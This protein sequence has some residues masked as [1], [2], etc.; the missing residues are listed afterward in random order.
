MQRDNIIANMDATDSY[1]SSSY[2]DNEPIILRSSTTT[3]IRQPIITNNRL[4][5]TLPIDIMNASVING[6]KSLTPPPPT[7]SSL[8]NNIKSSSPPAS[9]IINTTAATTTNA[10][11]TNSS[12]SRNLMD[13]MKER[14][15]QEVRR[16]LNGSPFLENQTA[17]AVRKNLS[18]PSMPLIYASNAATTT[19]N[20]SNITSHLSNNNII[21]SPAATRIPQRPLVQSH[22]FTTY[23]KSPP[24]PLVKRQPVH[25]VR[26]ASTVNELYGGGGGGGIYSLNNGSKPIQV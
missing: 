13:R 17:I 10:T 12:S 24:T 15:R 6:R 14:H 1:F 5:N 7:S 21:T 8:N 4:S 2:A 26:S 3:P 25:L 9:S 22:S 18:S 11:P 20:D 23:G 19:N 16:S